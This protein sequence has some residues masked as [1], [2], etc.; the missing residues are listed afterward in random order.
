MTSVSTNIASVNNWHIKYLIT[1]GLVTIIGGEAS[2][3]RR[4]GDEVIL[5]RYDVMIDA[6]SSCCYNS[7]CTCI[8]SLYIYWLMCAMHAIIDLHTKSCCQH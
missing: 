3:S 1:S 7:S 8:K 6:L 4:G 5:G 2:R